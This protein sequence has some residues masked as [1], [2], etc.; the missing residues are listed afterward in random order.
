VVLLFCCLLPSVFCANEQEAQFK[1]WM[2]I[3]NKQYESRAETARRFEIFV[4]NL[5]RYAKLNAQ[6]SGKV[7]H[8]P[9][10]FS[11]IAHEEFLQKYMLKNITSP[12]MRGEKIA[13]SEELPRT[14]LPSSYT[15]VTKGAVTPIYNQLQCGSC[16][17]FSTTEN[18]ES[19]NFIA[20]KTLT[21]LSMQQI[22]DCDTNGDGCNGG[23]PT[24]AYQYVISA[25][26]LETYA[27][28]PYTGQQGNCQ[29]QSSLIS[30]SISSWQYVTQSQDESQMQEFTYSKGPPSVLVDASTWDSYQ[31]GV[32]TSQDCGTQLDHA[33][34]IVGW[35]VVQGQN[36]WIVRNS[37][38][39]SWGNA[40]YLYVAMGENACGI[41][42]ECTSCVV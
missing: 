31:G 35:D 18:I 30:Q 29:F 2:K 40:G 20:G 27:S 5:A 32:Y 3:Y 22:V 1:E 17:A 34:Q 8:G 24:T 26:G 13:V 39:T 7:F 6:G 42:L 15:W 41:A 11:D 28:Y 9:T 37:W 25:G 38:G 12:K 36:A 10:Q 19:M 21:S 16:W 4:Q 33:V 14:E 23:D